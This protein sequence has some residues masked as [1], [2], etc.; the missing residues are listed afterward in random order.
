M[1][2][3]T[4]AAALMHRM[5]SK[6][7]QCL[8]AGFSSQGSHDGAWPALTAFCLPAH[9]ASPCSA[10]LQVPAVCLRCAGSSMALAWGPR[11]L[12]RP[13]PSYPGCAFPTLLSLHICSLLCIGP[14][15]VKAAFSHCAVPCPACH[16][17]T[18]NVSSPE[19][20]AICLE[21]Q[22]SRSKSLGSAWPA[23][24]AG[25]LLLGNPQGER[26]KTTT[27]RCKTQLRA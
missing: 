13:Y 26:T 7:S 5:V 17:S 20:D 19:R 11:H 10:S 23:W 24:G 25:R 22:A 14:D 15:C 16:S 6:D 12:Q 27:L 1:R 2:P 4:K 9:R 18:A 21:S 3:H 8:A